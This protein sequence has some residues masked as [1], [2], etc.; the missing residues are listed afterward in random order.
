[1]MYKRTFREGI[2]LLQQLKKNGLEFDQLL[3]RALEISA[4]NPDI[5]PEDTGFPD[6]YLTLA[7]YRLNSILTR[8]VHLDDQRF[9]LFHEYKFAPPCAPSAVIPGRRLCEVLDVARNLAGPGFIIGVGH[10]LSAIVTLSLDEPAWEYMGSTIHNT[11]SV[12][13]LLWFRG[14]Y[15]LFGQL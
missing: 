12:E 9:N 14:T 3:M 13:T 7:L 5:S 2:P 6:S 8:I 10:F 11:F 4:S 1:M 15:A